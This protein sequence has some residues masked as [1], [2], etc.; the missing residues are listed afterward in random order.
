MRP[1]TARGWASASIV[2]VCAVFLAALA[3]TAVLRSAV[4]VDQVPG[5]DAG[6]GTSAALESARAQASLFAVH[7][8]VLGI[9]TGVVL[10]IRAS[11]PR[12]TG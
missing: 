8:L 9:A 10:L 4:L 3:A 2:F 12:S 1:T 6:L 5:A 11:R 7:L